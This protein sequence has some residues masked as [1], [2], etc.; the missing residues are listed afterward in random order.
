MLHY[1]HTLYIPLA[2][3]YDVSAI[4]FHFDDDGVLLLELLGLIN[5][6]VT[7]RRDGLGIKQDGVLL[8]GIRIL[9]KVEHVVESLDSLRSFVIDR[10]SVPSRL[11]LHGVDKGD[12]IRVQRRERAADGRTLTAIAQLQAD[13]AGDVA[14]RLVEA[15]Q[16]HRVGQ[17]AART[18]DGLSVAVVVTAVDAHDIGVVGQFIVEYR[19]TGSRRERQ[20]IVVERKG[21]QRLVALAGREKQTGESQ[22]I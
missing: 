22:Y 9:T 12:R 15:Y 8:M 20:R 3:P 7:A 19:A 17:G 4:V 13:L 16:L 10:E 11:H 2:L 1:L 18:Q 21:R 5:D 14:H 6:G